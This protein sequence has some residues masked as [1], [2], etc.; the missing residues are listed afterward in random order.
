VNG[1]QDPTSSAVALMEMARSFAELGKTGWRPQRTLVFALWDGEEWGLLGSTEWAEH[2]AGELK[3]K[4]VLY[5]NT[6]SYGWGWLGSAGSHGLRTF[7]EQVTRDAGDPASG[8]SALDALAARAFSQARTAQDSSRIRE[9]GYAIDALGSGSDY[10]V[11]LDHLNVASL[12]MGY[13]GGQETGIYHSVYDSYDFFV[14]FL[15]PG[16]LYGKA[17]AGAVGIALARLADAPLLPWSFVDA[18]NTYATYV[19]ELDTLSGKML[20]PGALDL[21]GVRQA[22]SDLTDAGRSF[23]AAYQRVIQQGTRALSGKRRQLEAVNREIYLSERD[24][25][26]GAGLPLRPWFRHMIYAPGYYTG[27]GVKT[28]PGIRE[29]IELNRLEE[30]RSQAAVVAA[31]IGRMAGRVRHATEL[32]GSL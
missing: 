8:G 19:A 13:G 25:G 20:R 11:F 6:D 21:S 10:T 2:H 17:Q 27:Y 32:L 18:A 14:R 3:Q 12:N 23:D 5:L 22:V 1:A 26:N 4:A 9:R 31:A 30:A 29:A 28:M 16:F 7:A 15:D 24:L